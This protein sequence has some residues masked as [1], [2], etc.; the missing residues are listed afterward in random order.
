[1]ISLNTNVG[2]YWF[3]TWLES[4]RVTTKSEAAFLLGKPSS[5]GELRMVA[6]QWSQNAVAPPPALNL[7]AGAG[8][9]MNDPMSCPSPNCRRHQ[10]E[11]LFRHAWHYFDSILLP[12]VIGGLLL[13][14]S[15]HFSSEGLRGEIL[16]MAEV[17]LYI[18]NIGASGLVHYYPTTHGAYGHVESSCLDQPSRWSEAWN[19]VKKRRFLRSHHFALRR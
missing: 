5:I 2:P 18:Q 10:I 19:I 3:L 8:L 11:V 7:V 1:M 6:E 16:N 9:R 17:V 15:D 4:K 14:P 12:D 13:N